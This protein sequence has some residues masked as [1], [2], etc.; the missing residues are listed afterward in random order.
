[1]P[2]ARSTRALLAFWIEQR[3]V[4]L[5]F[6]RGSEGARYAHVRDLTARK[7]TRLARRYTIEHRARQRYRR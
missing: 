4:V 1:M 6:F 2:G 5:T 3:L 7:M